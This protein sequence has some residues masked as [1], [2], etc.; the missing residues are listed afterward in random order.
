M[1][2]EIYSRDDRKIRGIYVTQV[3]GG[4]DSDEMEVNFQN[5][6]VFFLP[7]YRMRSQ[8]PTQQ[9]QWTHKSSKS[10]RRRRGINPHSEIH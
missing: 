10:A 5:T 1:F 2:C 3:L 6:F 4:V 7:S 8:I 9:E